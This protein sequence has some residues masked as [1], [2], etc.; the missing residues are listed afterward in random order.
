M[1]SNSGPSLKCYLLTL[2]T[3]INQHYANSV[4]QSYSRN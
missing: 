1:K 4:Y 3:D 2:Y